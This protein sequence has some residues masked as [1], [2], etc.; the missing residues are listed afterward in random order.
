MKYDLNKYRR[1]YKSVISS[2]LS[3]LIIFGILVVAGVFI[4][5]W[6]TFNDFWIWI[7]LS[8]SFFTAISSTISYLAKRRQVGNDYPQS[9]SNNE[10]VSSNGNM[11]S[12]PIINN[13]QESTFPKESTSKYCK[14]CGVK[15]EGN[16]TYC[17][18]CGALI[19]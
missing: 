13:Y 7:I 6:W 16:E 17:I 19:E 18:N 12:Q 4:K 14:F 9:Y 11:H 1:N 10:Y 15:L 5:E 8:I 2:W 3:F